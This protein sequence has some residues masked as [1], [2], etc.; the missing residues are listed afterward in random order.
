M[1]IVDALQ[2]AGSAKRN[3]MVVL[4]NACSANSSVG[5]IPCVCGA[6]MRVAVRP[7]ERRK[8]QPDHTDS[9]HAAKKLYTMRIHKMLLWH[10]SHPEAYLSSSP[11]QHDTVAVHTTSRDLHEGRKMYMCRKYAFLLR[12]QHS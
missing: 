3:C 6:L 10:G 8:T 2:G 5:C 12:G 9:T 7:R 1:V 11:V 4:T